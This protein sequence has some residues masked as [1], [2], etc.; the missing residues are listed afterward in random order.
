MYNLFANIC[1]SQHWGRRE[2]DIVHSGKNKISWLTRCGMNKL[3]FQSGV[4]TKFDELCSIE[5]VQGEGVL[6][7]HQQLILCIRYWTQTT[8]Y[9]FNTNLTLLESGRLLKM[10]CNI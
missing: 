8:L 1:K 5:E 2:E 10:P 6:N 9:L 4:L 7:L 3:L